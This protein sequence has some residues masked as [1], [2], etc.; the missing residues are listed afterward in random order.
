MPGEMNL[1]LLCEK[2]APTL[3]QGTFVYCCLPR[4]RFPLPIEPLCSFKEA[5]GVTVILEKEAAN[6]LNLKYQYE[7]AMITL[8]VHSALDAVGFVAIISNEL[9]NRNIPC[10]VVSAFHHDH[11]FVPY[12]QRDQAMDALRAVAS[13][14]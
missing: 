12:S 11:L 3:H 2:M 1:A 14:Q 9:A 6:A 4:E 8:T 13:R 7:C 10:N 5:E